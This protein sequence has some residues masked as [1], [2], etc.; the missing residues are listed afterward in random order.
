M[1]GLGGLQALGLEMIELILIR[2]TN[3]TRVR[4]T[5]ILSM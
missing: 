4:H 3:G 1:L 5:L 2:H